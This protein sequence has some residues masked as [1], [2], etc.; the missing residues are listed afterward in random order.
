M[1]TGRGGIVVKVYRLAT[2]SFHSFG[3]A[4]THSYR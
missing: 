4:L 2:V 3:S 1:I